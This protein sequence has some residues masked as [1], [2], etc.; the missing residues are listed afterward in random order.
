MNIATAAT[1]ASER[2]MS[3]SPPVAR[4]NP[5]PRRGRAADREAISR[6]PRW[7]SDRALGPKYDHNHTARL[8]SHGPNGR[9]DELIVA[10]LGGSHLLDDGPGAHNVDPVTL[11]KTF[12]LRTEPHKTTTAFRLLLQ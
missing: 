9:G 4:H 1:R 12:V 8:A 11:L 10:G 7:S 5:N 6:P 2:F 3:S